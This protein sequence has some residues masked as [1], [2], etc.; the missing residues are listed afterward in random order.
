MKKLFVAAVL[1][2]SGLPA[3]AQAP[4]GDQ[5]PTQGGPGGGRFQGGG[6][7]GPNGPSGPSG[8]GGPGGPGGLV[9]GAMMQRMAGELG[10]SPEKLREAFR[11]ARQQAGERDAGAGGPG[12]AGGL[13]APGS[14]GGGAGGAPTAEQRAA[15][16]KAMAQQLNVTPERLEEVMRKYQGNHMGP[17]GHGVGR[18][19]EGANGG[20]SAGGPGGSGAGAGAG[21]GAGV[22]G[23]GGISNGGGPDGPAV[24]GG[25]GGANGG[26]PTFGR[27]RGQGF[28]SGNGPLARRRAQQQQQQPAADPNQPGNQ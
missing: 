4:Q 11:N 12:A 20:P 22:G 25:A 24:N 23:P 5:G 10:V 15:R 16:H 3:L 18:F 9:R 2:I 7:G 21:A 17:G 13:G 6:L 1:L 19:G 14:P 26:G 8:P 28:G 27:F